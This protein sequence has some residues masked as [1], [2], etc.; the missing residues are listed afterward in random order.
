MP[1]NL[2]VG[3]DLTIRRKI[4]N[5]R[6]YWGKGRDG[7]RSGK[8]RRPAARRT[9]GWLEASSEMEARQGGDA[10]CGSVISCHYMS[11]AALPSVV[12]IV[13]MAVPAPTALVANDSTLPSTSIA[14]DI[15]VGEG[16]AFAD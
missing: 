7:G 9:K 5:G 6:Y 10:A 14:F 13:P 16:S 8:I 1:A 3:R 12:A 4:E 15:L 11:P 2:P